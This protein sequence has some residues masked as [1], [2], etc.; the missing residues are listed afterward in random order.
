MQYFSC[1][2]VSILRTYLF[3]RFYTEYLFIRLCGY[4]NDVSFESGSENF[5]LQRF[6]SIFIFLQKINA[7]CVTQQV[8]SSPLLC[9][10]SAFTI[11]P[12]K[13][14]PQFR[15]QL[16]D[17]SIITYRILY[18]IFYVV[19]NVYATVRVLYAPEVHLRSFHKLL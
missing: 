12:K 19:C 5:L 10:T 13:S 4:T 11:I 7:E 15:E 3:F 6:A 16:F 2:F 17:R 14:C 1:T 9:N 18:C 8:F